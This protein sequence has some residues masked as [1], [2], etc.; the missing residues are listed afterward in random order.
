MVLFL[1]GH[2]TRGYPP[3]FPPSPSS[4]P[5]H[6]SYRLLLLPS[7]SNKSRRWAHSIYS[8]LL[9]PPLFLPF[10][11][12][13]TRDTPFPS[14]DVRLPYYSMSC[15]SV[16][17]G[18]V[19]LA[20]SNLI[21]SLHRSTF[22]GMNETTTTT[23]EE[24]VENDVEFG[25]MLSFY[26]WALLGFLALSLSQSVPGNPSLSLSFRTPLH[27]ETHF[28]HFSTFLT[29]PKIKEVPIYLWF[30][31]RMKHN[32]NLTYYPDIRQ[33]DCMIINHLGSW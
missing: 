12:P 7:Q 14:Y 3:S 9:L 30:M 18:R 5:L 27:F 2:S 31:N 13:I 11:L 29:G 26:L 24:I 33:W 8:Y 28:W 21:I 6:F 17:T 32:H 1:R 4:S 23:V 16:Q 25:G 19:F 15:V 20:H 22:A 10:P